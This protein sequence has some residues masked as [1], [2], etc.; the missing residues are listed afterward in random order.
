[1]AD[2][3]E[4]PPVIG[5]VIW[6]GARIIRIPGSPGCGPQDLGAAEAVEENKIIRWIGTTSAL[7]ATS[8]AAIAA[9]AEAQQRN[10]RRGKQH[11]TR[12]S[13]S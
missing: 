9:G 1:M 12:V 11:L 3:P 2:H 8:T 4:E 10:F 6:D 5:P 7:R 13:L